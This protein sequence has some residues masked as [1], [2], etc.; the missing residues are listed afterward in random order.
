MDFHNIKIAALAMY[1]AGGKTLTEVS[2]HFNIKGSSTLCNW[3]HRDQRDKADAI[4]AS[5]RDARPTESLGGLSLAEQRLMQSRLL[6][7]E[8]L[9]DVLLEHV[10]PSTKKKSGQ[11]Q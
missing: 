11:R 9:V 3:I 8:V 10:P 5:A 6:R 4:E 7:L 1:Y 2:R